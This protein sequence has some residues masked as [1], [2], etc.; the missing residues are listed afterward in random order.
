MATTTS[1]ETATGTP[2]LV[3]VD[4]P[5]MFSRHDLL[6]V[7]ESEEAA[8]REGARLAILIDLLG[9]GSEIAWA[10]CAATFGETPR[11]LRTGIRAIVPEV[12]AAQARD[13]A[14][15]AYVAAYTT[16]APVGD[17]DNYAIWDRIVSSRAT[18]RGGPA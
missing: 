4:V 14:C 3:C 18:D 2:W 17:E 10:A 16:A 6:V 8:C 11:F 15:V 12:R 5:D 9:P 13:E 1:P 7:A